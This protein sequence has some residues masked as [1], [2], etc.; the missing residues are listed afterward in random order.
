MAMAAGAALMVLGVATPNLSSSADAAERARNPQQQRAAAAKPQH[1]G[2][3]RS[4]RGT[5]SYYAQRFNG[6][7][8]ANGK[9]FDARSNSAAHRTLPLGTTARVTN[10]E[11]GRSVEVKVE[12]RGPYARNRVIDLSPRTAQELGMKEQGT[13][14]VVVTPVQVPDQDERYAQR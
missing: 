1:P 8:M 2:A 13:A 12:D 11:N 6:R 9:R 3:A 5:A 7:R 14:Q 10:V 4:Q